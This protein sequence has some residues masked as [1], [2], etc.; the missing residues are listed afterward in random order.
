MT[1]LSQIVCDIAQQRI[2]GRAGYFFGLLLIIEPLDNPANS[3]H[4]REWRIEHL[5][6]QQG[7][8]DAQTDRLQH[9]DH[10]ADNQVGKIHNKQ[11]AQQIAD[12]P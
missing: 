1:A 7:K 6:Y 12:L 10:K 8:V 9:S 2:R 3:G 4:Q 5:E 11:H